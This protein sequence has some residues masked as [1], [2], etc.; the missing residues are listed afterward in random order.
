MT[1]SV[2]DLAAKPQV[3]LM[4]ILD[5][6]TQSGYKCTLHRKTPLKFREL[7][8]MAVKIMNDFSFSVVEQK[9]PA[10]LSLQLTNISNKFLMV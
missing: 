3:L 2:A 1:G 7:S 5:E 9:A 4:D 6:K 10:L 8:K